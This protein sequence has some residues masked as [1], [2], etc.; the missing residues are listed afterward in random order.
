M[1][2]QFL[3]SMN[4]NTSRTFCLQN[5]GNECHIVSYLDFHSE[6]LYLCLFFVGT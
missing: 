1:K 3:L 2:L 5:M 6:I 4:R